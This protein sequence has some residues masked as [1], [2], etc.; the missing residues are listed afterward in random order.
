MKRSMT[1][2][3]NWCLDELLPPVLR[4]SSFF[5]SI[6][7]RIALGKKYHFYQ[8]FKDKAADLDEKQISSYY[9]LLADTFIQRETDNNKKCIDYICQSAKADYKTV[10]DAA[11][12]KGYLVHK[13]Y[14]NDK[15]KEYYAVDIVLPENKRNDIHYIQAS[16][17]NLPFENNSID[18]VICTHAL[19]H[20]KDNSLALSELR[21]VCKKKLIIVLPKQREYKFTFDLHVHFYPYLY[22]VKNYINNPKAKIFNLGNDWVIVEEY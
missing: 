7:F 19:E 5:M 14:E 12:G 18:L 20:V 17:T 6:L 8:E 16:I 4:D 21:R 15:N 1:Q 9:E 22:S 11:C 3:I 2:R 13:I 10:L